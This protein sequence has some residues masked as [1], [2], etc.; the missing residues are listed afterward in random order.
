[1]I[2]NKCKADKPENEFAWS[3]RDTKR[4]KR[5][6]ACQAE[7]ARAHYQANKEKYRK[8]FSYNQPKY[9]IR[10]RRFFAQWLSQQECLVCG[11]NDPLVLVCHHRDSAEKVENVA[12]MVQHRYSIEKIKQEIA[13]CDVLCHNCHAR[14]HYVLDKDGIRLRKY[15]D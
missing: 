9:R 4:S 14:E 6:R 3:K 7:Y 12:T 10:N 11:E 8:S 2:C 15:Y 1:M 5:C 13:K